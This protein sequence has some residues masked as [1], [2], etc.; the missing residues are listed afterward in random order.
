MLYTHNR[1]G[2]IISCGR[3][4]LDEYFND[5]WIYDYREDQ[6]KKMDQTYISI[7]PEIRYSPIGGTYPGY[8]Y[9]SDLKT[10]LFLGMGRSQY[11]MYDNMF[12][13]QFT[14]L[15]SLTGIWEYGN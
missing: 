7:V 4:W 14:D 9:S 6:W 12:S 10:N 5:L 3:G 11:T 1:H 2:L 15:R 8:E 13:Y